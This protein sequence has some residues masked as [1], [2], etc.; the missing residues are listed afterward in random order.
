MPSRSSGVGIAVELDGAAGGVDARV[1]FG[2]HAARLDMAFIGI[3]QRRRGN[4]LPAR[5]RVRSTPCASSRWWP[6]VSL[7][8]RSKSAR[9]RACA[10]TS[11]PLNGVSGK[12]SRH[13]SSERTPSRPITGSEVSAS[14]QGASMPPAQWLVES[15][16]VG[17]AALVQRDGMAGLREQQRLPCAGNARADDGN[18]GIPPRDLTSGTSLSLRRHD[19][20]QVQ[21]VTAVSARCE[22]ALKLAVSQLL[23]GAPLGTGLM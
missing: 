23:I 6:V 14:H 5:V 21:R 12:C 10:T 8:K 1:Q 9:S 15:V 11:E 2:Q 3:E 18:G 22:A 4:G 19:P 7:A 17:V 20:D 13:R 16:I